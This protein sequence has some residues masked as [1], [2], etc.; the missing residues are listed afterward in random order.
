MDINDFKDKFIEEASG[1]LN[2]LEKDILTLEKDPENIKLI[3]EVFRVMHTLKG[4]S[5]M[6]GFD[7]VGELTHNLENIFDLIRAGD[8]KV[9]T[10]ILDITL[11]SCDHINALLLDPDFSDRKNKRNHKKME[12]RIADILKTAGKKVKKTVSQKD[13]ENKQTATFN[14]LF[15][16]DDSILTRN[17]NLVSLFKE[18]F[19]LGDY[20]IVHPKFTEEQEHWSIFLV[21]DKKFGDIAESLF[22]ILD[23]C[24][25]IKIA[26]FDIFNKSELEKHE[27][28]SSS[29]SLSDIAEDGIVDETPTSDIKIKKQNLNR[30]AVDSEKLDQLM[31]LVSELITTNSQLRLKTNTKNYDPIK[32]YL[33]KLNNLSNSFRNN[34]IEIR[35]VPIEDL[36]IKFQRLVRDLSKSLNKE[37]E[38]ITQGANTELD[39]NTID[40]LSEPLMHIIR[41]CIDHGIQ[42]PDARKANGKQPKG[43]IKLVAFHSGNNVFIQ[44]QDDGMG[45]NTDKV[46]E[47]AIE[48]GFIKKNTELSKKEILDLIFKPGFSTAQSLTEVSGRGVGLDVVKQS[49][50]D[51][52]GEIEVT[53]EKGLGTSFTLKL[54]QSLAIMDTMLFSME[55]T[56][57]LVPMEDIELCT[58][59]DADFIKKHSRTNLLPYKKEKIPFVNLRKEFNTKTKTPNRQ[60]TIIIRKN[61]KLFAIIADRIL[62]KHQAVLKNI[63]KEYEELDYLSG[64]SVLADGNIAL[65]FD[66]GLLYERA[67]GLVKQ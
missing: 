15:Y 42:S 18:L 65:L 6:Y 47:K 11:L 57:F 52:R 55:E 31:F 2:N 60:E 58:S 17:I 44:I 67:K 23:D 46:K 54:Q 12:L 32:P 66:N 26:D 30:I 59:Y 14:I 22:F 24:K 8:I 21:T 61:E 49:I 40:M 9:S 20:K 3:E 16:P 37:V 13:E 51:L 62:G 35:L 43:I 50:V 34:A 29:Q 56:A 53:T 4:V 27:Q 48:K 5:S 33:D 63:A 64:A 7:N 25:I 10:E 19:S 36:A 1:L 41:N 38:F 39:K 28:R 45:I